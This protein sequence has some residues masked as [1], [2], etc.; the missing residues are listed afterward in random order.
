MRLSKQNSYVLP[1]VQEQLL[2][3]ERGGMSACQKYHCYQS[4][5]WPACAAPRWGEPVLGMTPVRDPLAACCCFPTQRG[6]CI[7]HFVL[8][9][10]FHFKTI[11]LRVSLF[12]LF[13]SEKW[14][15]VFSAESPSMFTKILSPLRWNKGEEALG[16]WYL[17]QIWSLLVCYFLWKL[18]TY[19]ILW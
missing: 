11:L 7:L 6:F 3:A 18:G 5:H 12:W 16:I 9:W 1:V 10:K 17:Q 15:S 13:V 4:Q 2:R 14:D 8:L 19:M